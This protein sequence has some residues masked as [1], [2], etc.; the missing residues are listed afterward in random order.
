[1]TD[2]IDVIPDFTIA[3]VVCTL[4]TTLHVRA[5]SF[6]KQQCELSQV[7]P[8]VLD[9]GPTGD[10]G[11]FPIEIIIL[12]LKWIMNLILELPFIGGRK[13]A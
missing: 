4:K 5:H 13:N 7:Y 1:M 11:Y 12:Q 6:L 3:E 8:A 9:N 10:F 2:F